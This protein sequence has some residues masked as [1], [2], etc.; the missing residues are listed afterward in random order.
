MLHLLYRPTRAL[1]RTIRPT[2]GKFASATDEDVVTVAIPVRGYFGRADKIPRMEGN[3]SGLRKP[4]L[5]L[6]CPR[7]EIIPV[8]ASSFEVPKGEGCN[9]VHGFARFAKHRREQGVAM[10][11]PFARAKSRVGAARLGS[12]DERPAIVE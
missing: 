11:H 2:Q 5:T 1:P 7:S 8:A 6:N 9:F 3:A 12:L 4:L 10:N